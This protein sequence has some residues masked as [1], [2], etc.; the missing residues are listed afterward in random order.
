MALPALE[1]ARLEL[2]LVAQ[3]RDRDLL[4]VLAVEDGGAMRGDREAASRSD[5]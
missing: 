4:Q 5:G 2:V 1:D 3:V